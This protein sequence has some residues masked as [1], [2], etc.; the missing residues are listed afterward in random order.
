MNK[1]EIINIYGSIDNFQEIF[2]N[3]YDRFAE[4]EEI[5]VDIICKESDN[6]IMVVSPIFSASIIENILFTNNVSIEIIDTPEAI[7][8]R[9]IIEEDNT[10]DYKEHYMR[11]IKR[12]QTASYNLLKVLLS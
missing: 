2:P 1:I 11:E 9:L 3:D 6:F 5:M 7:H 8:D 12:D 10:L 4:K